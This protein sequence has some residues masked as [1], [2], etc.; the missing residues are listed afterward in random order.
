MVHEN[1]GVVGI[2]SLGGENVVPYLIDCLRSLQHRGQESWGIA[3]PKKMPFKKTEPLLGKT[4]TSFFDFGALEYSSVTLLQ[5]SSSGLAFYP[6]VLQAAL[7][8]RL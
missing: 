1:C 4:I 6:D 3:V 2:F 7:L 5:E 8:E